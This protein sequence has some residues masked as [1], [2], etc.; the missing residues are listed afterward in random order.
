MT[1]AIFIIDNDLLCFIEL[2][3]LYRPRDLQELDDLYGRS[4]YLPFLYDLN[5]LYM[6]FVTSHSFRDL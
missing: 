1:L 2:G 4:H 3:Y 5:N 6:A